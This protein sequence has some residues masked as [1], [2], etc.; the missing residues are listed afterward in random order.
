MLVL[1]RLNTCAL[2]CC[3]YLTDILV[4]I[5]TAKNDLWDKVYVALLRE[6]F[7]TQTIKTEYWV[8]C[9]VVQIGRN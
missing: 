9:D 2:P 3:L 4:E 8:G 1:R 6:R 5:I 7:L